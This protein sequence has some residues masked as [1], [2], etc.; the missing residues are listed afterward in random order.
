M[1]YLLR[2]Q[3]LKHITNLFQDF[4]EVRIIFLQV[5]KLENQ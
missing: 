4:V 1:N 3:N 5:I 2:S